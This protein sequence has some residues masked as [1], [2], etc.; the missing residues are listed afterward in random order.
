MD[1]RLSKLKEALDKNFKGPA[2]YMFKFIV[3]NN[4]K[5]LAQVMSLFD[6]SSIISSR[7]SS[8]GKYMS[9]TAREISLDV[10]S[11]IEKYKLAFQ[12]EGLIAL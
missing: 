9:V 6:D 11:I 10:E 3:P 7:Q 8:N 12:I 1:E 2:V 5:A 4:N